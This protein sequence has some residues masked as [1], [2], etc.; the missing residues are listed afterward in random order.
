MEKKTSTLELKSY[1][2]INLFLEVLQRLENNYH[3][4]STFFSEIELY[5]NIKFSLTK[6]QEINM[7]CTNKSL[8][9]SENLI[10]KIAIYIQAI[11]SVQCGALLE[12]EKNIPIAAGLGGGS[13]N[14]AT[15]IKGLS[16]L[17][18]LNLSKREMHDIGS[19][20]GSDI[21]FFL[22]GYQAI[23]SN[24]GE[25][26]EP[27]LD[28][29]NLDN[30]LLVNPN[31]FISSGEAYEMLYTD[32][33]FSLPSHTKNKIS[34]LKQL[35]EKQNPKFCFNRLERGIC[36]RY[37]ILQETLNKLNEYGAQKAMLSGSGPTMIGIFADPIS[38]KKAQK[39]M[40]EMHFWSFKTTTRRRPK[41]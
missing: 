40:E 36:L 26:I 8:V 4:I 19:K 32:D 29:I 38:L 39:S 13:S 41:K 9:S 17:W 25:L 15:T 2:K 18:D 35:L 10:Y 3:G 20:F 33:T 34:F 12:L 24:R 22:E 28:E 5:D 14:A 11:Y 23:G 16:E 1:A 30:I 7:L 27:I 37:P 31:F 21:N 6:N